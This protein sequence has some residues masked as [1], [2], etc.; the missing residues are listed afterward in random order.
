MRLSTFA[1]FCIVTF[2]VTVSA[3]TQTVPAATA[4]TFTLEAGV[5]GS[6]IQPDYRGR[7]IAEASPD[8]LYGAGVYVDADFTRWIQIEAEG[9]WLHFN[10]YLGIDEN[11]YLIGPRIPI[12]LDYHGLTP[13]GKFLIGMANGSFLTGNSLALAY[14]GGVDYRLSRRFTIRA[15][16]FEYQQWRLS[17]TISPYGGSVGFS[18]R[19]F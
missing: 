10:K 11:T 9:R 18:Y 1:P 5:Q 3:H 2:L 16:D 4:S 17:P 8:H 19:V 14:G 13:Y 15:F 12:V 7:G 6:R